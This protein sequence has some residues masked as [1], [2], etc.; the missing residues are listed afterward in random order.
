MVNRVDVTDEALG[1]IKMLKDKYGNIL[2]YQSGGCCDGSAVMCYQEGDFLIGDNDTLLGTIGYV[3]F[4]MHKS[5]YNYWKHTQLIIDV[6]DGEGPAFS[7]DS[8]EEKHFITRSR[9]FTNEEYEEINKLERTIG[10]KKP[11][12]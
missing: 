8:L 5:Q 6:A 1:F 7:L 2:F 9:V 3:P 10:I 12:F 4:Y 11:Y